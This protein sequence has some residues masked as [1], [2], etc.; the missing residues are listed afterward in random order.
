VTTPQNTQLAK[1][2]PLQI[3][4]RKPEVVEKFIGLFPN[5]RAANR[6]IQSVLILVQTSDPG[7]YSLQNCSN[8]SV[9]RSALRA[10]SLR[11][12]VDPAL[13]QAWLVPRFNGK[14]RSLEA[15]L[16][17]HY[18][19]IYNRAMRTGRYQVIN[20][21]AVY[22]GERVFENIYTGFHQIALPSEAMPD[23]LLMTLPS[24]R[25]GFVEVGSRKGKEIGLLGYYKTTKGAE[26]T[27]YMS[28]GDIEKHVA[29]YNPSW[30][31]SKAW[32]ENRKTMEYKTV[33]LQLLKK[34]DLSDDGLSDIKEIIDAEGQ[35][36]ADT[37][38]GETIESEID[39]E[40]EQEPE[41]PQQEQQQDAP[42]TPEEEAYYN[43]CDMTT[44]KGATLAS[45]TSLQLE[46]VSTS[47]N[48]PELAKAATIIIAWRNKK[49]AQI[50]A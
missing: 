48:H 30:Q 17:L 50:T 33:L 7:D 45:L 44:P 16:Q 29:Q 10:A 11:V 37:V 13:R 14:T 15:G 5:D 39:A 40:P 20:V 31:K 3:Y 4:M 28:I 35:E 41:Q 27:V 49:R 18:A 26:K 23:G 47:T 43:A 38:E 19:E 6:F 2:E 21:S 34:A 8:E 9:L 1:S 42:I 22:E 12:S 25:S 32:R 46:A 24:V 36:D